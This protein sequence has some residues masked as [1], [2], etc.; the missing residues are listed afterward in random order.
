MTRRTRVVPEPLVLPGGD[1]RPRRVSPIARATARVRSGDIE[2]PVAV[3]WECVVLAV[4]TAR[5]SG[6]AIAIRGRL[7][8]SGQLD[9]LHTGALE[10]VVT[11]ATEWARNLSLPCVLVLEAPWGGSVKIVAS[12][13]ASSERWLRPWLAA[14]EAHARVVKVMP[15]QWRG[16]VL[17]A[18]YVSCPRDKVRAH[19][20]LIASLMLGRPAGDDEAPAVL[21]A[22]WASH[23]ARI[24]R[25]IG[26]R[27]TRA[28]LRA[29]EA[30]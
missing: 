25:V 11:L 19:E 14:G 15:N 27:A 29:W 7:H 10:R 23:A 8:S 26:K 20:Q 22:L 16:P 1:V 30:T 13:G 9:T 2:A 17:G 28:T 12:L 3:P 24:G 4:D 21:I 5:V 18:A 6:W